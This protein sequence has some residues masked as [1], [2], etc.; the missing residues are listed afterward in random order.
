MDVPMLLPA[1]DTAT[2]AADGPG[3]L[4]DTRPP[5]A[6]R[7]FDGGTMGAGAESPV[8]ERGPEVMT[9]SS[10]RSPSEVKT[11][12]TRPCDPQTVD[13]VPRDGSRIVANTRH[14]RG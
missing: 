1:P 7:P 5:V 2:A 11:F 14:V 4:L 3:T 10:M 9:R 13:V 6:G 8:A 12:T